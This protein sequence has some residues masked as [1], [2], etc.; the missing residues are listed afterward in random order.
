[1]D[2]NKYKKEFEWDGSWRDLYILNTDISHWQPLID[3]L[4]GGACPIDWIVIDRLSDVRQPCVAA[5][6]VTPN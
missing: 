3:L 1:M 5:I 6:E 2:W 4:R